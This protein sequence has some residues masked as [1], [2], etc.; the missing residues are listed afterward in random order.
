M[1]WKDTRPA[2]QDPTRRFES[3]PDT[4]VLQRLHDAHCHPTDDDAFS[5][6]ELEQLHT[7]VLCAM[8]SSLSNQA[9]TREIYRECRDRVIPCFGVHPWFS[10]PISFEPRTSLPSRED[11]YRSVFSIPNRDAL[12]G[13]DAESN[14][15]SS[16]AA[17]LDRLLPYF[18]DPVSIEDVLS[19]LERDLSTTDS[20]RSMVGEIGIDKAFKIPHAPNL[21][22]LD[23]TLPKNSDLQTPIAHQVKVVEA[24]LDAAIRLRK[25]VSFHSVRATQDTTELLN[26]CKK[27]KAGFREIHV[28]LHSFGA[29]P[30]A[31]RQ[32][33]RNHPNVFFS[34]STIISDR[35][36]QFHNLLRAIEPDRLLVESD[37][38]DT[39]Q[40]DLQIWEVFEAIC[41][42]RAWTHDEALSTLERNWARYTQPFDERPPPKKSNKERKR[43]RKQVDLYVSDDEDAEGT[44]S[45]NGSVPG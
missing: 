3:P 1:P 38:S 39:S 31:A 7:G 13:A 15:A 19:Q 4:A 22:A 11:H 2:A 40:I 14:P 41:A 27:D 44:R 24:Q 34:F 25:N 10:H 9:K 16:S 20:D 21:I 29:S 18:P 32:V 17:A 37:F 42:A 23:P 43:E 5:R 6:F 33:Q 45:T 12:D 35:S 36:P 26:R 8:S 30:E 28:C